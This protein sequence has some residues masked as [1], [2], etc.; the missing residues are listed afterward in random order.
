MKDR[1]EKILKA[2]QNQIVRLISDKRSGRIEITV[3]LNMTQGFIG[4]AD[5]RSSSRENIFSAK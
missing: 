3:E 2:V 1:E 4:S 5:I